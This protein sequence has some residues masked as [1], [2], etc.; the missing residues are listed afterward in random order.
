MNP[1]VDAL[2]RPGQLSIIGD[3]DCAERRSTEAFISEVFARRFSA[4]LEHFFPNIAATRTQTGEINAAAGYRAADS[5]R[6]FLEQ[7]LDRPI[8]A[9]IRYH[10]GEVVD[11]ARIVEVGSLAT[12]GGRAAVGL[13]AALIRHLIAEGFVWAVFTGNDAVRNLFQKLHLFPFAICCADAAQLREA[14]DC[15]GTYYDHHPIVMAGR[16]TD[17]ATAISVPQRTSRAA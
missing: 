6:L 13:I 5:S 8:E 7:Y 2:E 4:R 3:Y 15:W 12:A 9:T 17:G 10:F 1:A 16:L 14:G 11:R